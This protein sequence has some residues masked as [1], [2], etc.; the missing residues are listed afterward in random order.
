M[1]TLTWGT[2][3]LEGFSRRESSLVSLRTEGTIALE[4][5]LCLGS[6]D[7]EPGVGGVRGQ[8]ARSGDRARRNRTAVSPGGPVRIALDEASWLFL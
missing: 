5:A 1:R 4:V 8:K 2:T 7:W 3:A 6:R